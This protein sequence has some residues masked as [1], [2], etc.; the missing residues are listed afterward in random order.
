MQ[1]KTFP[2]IEGP[3][4]LTPKIFT[5][6]RGSF[7]ESFR[8]DVFE[9][10]IGKEH[11]FIQDNQSISLT[12]G[13][14]R[15]L[16][17]QTM[18]HA[19]GKLVR[20]VIGSILDVAVDVRRGSPTYGQ[21]VSTVL[22]GEG[23]EQLWV[24]QGFLHGFV[25]REDNCTVAYKCTDYYAQECERSVR[26]NDPDLAIDWGIKDAIVSDKDRDAIAFKDFV[27]PF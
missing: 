11:K 7:M 27:S 19:Q 16:H 10:H 3:L 1:V 18:P 17:L 14:V 4:L 23:G 8:V 25:T 22:S 24:P 21:Y 5:D 15:G 12:R 2:T 9:K 26:W 20:C 13:T 6:N